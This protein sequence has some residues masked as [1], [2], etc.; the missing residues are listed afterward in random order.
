VVYIGSL[1]GKVYALD[2][3]TGALLWEQTL[4]GP[5]FGGL[6][7]SSDG[8]VYVGTTNGSVGAGG[9]LFKLDAANGNILW[10]T[11]LGTPIESSVAL[12]RD[13]SVVY[14]GGR[15]GK[16]YGLQAA[17]GATASGWP[18]NTGATIF[19]SSP[20]VDGADNVYIGSFDGKL[21]SISPAGMVN[22][23]FDTGSPIVASPALQTSPS[24]VAS[25]IY[26]ASYDNNSGNRDSKVF[27]LD[28]SGAE[29]WHFPDAGGEDIDLISSSPAIGRDGTLYFG[30]NNKNVY[31]VD[32][33]GTFRW[34]YDT[35]DIVESSPGIGPDG[36]IYVGGWG[37]KVFALR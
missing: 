27:A 21:Y 20:A 14:L 11:N 33:N 36:T 8:G 34:A 18:V 29:I 6:T 13:E 4:N 37:G 1:D 25:R 19:V 30:S 22:W 5:V 28:S 16:V 24:S 35:G 23:S 32:S 17:S 12:S 9:S 31:A 7:L 3:E 2:T 10:S 26:V 15:D